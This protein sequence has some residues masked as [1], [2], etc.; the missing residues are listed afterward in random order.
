MLVG[1]MATKALEPLVP[2]DG[3]TFSGVMII[4]KRLQTTLVQLATPLMLF[5]ADIVRIIRGRVSSSLL[6]LFFVAAAGTLIGSVVGT[7]LFGTAMTDTL[8]G[9]G[10]ADAAWKL[11]GAL[12]AKNI[13]GGMNYVAAATVFSL[14]PRVFAMGLAVDNVAALIYFP[15]CSYLGSFGRYDPSEGAGDPHVDRATRAATNAGVAENARATPRL[16][17][18]SL[19]LLVALSVTVVSNVLAPSPFEILA[20][21]AMT[22]TI[23]SVPAL[24]RFMPRAVVDSG[25][26]LGTALLY[27]FFASAGVTAAAYSVA[28]Y[29]SWMGFLIVM[30]VVHFV[31]VLGF[32]WLSGADLPLAL[33]ASSASI[34]NPATAASLATS[35]GWNE[36]ILPGILVGQLGN[37]V[38]TFASTIWGYGV[39]RWLL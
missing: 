31:F 18:A 29:P 23:A 35:K 32:A 33:I 17:S 9:D 8:G 14:E 3:Q 37:A 20:A 1:F 27:I 38:A 21:T 39:L 15:L 7:F 2:F 24:S 34:G 12:C 22:I 19:A 5:D 30:Y 11:A 36:L 25:Q 10:G 16:H 28:F 4:V 6:V 13:G 26:A